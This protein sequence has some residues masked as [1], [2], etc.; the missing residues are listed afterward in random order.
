MIR[1]YSKIAKLA[2][3][4][5]F[6]AIV[7]STWVLAG[8]VNKLIATDSSGV[9]IKGYDTVAYF[10]EGRAVKGKEELEFV[11]QDA[12]WRFS[13]A[14]HRDMFAASPERYAPKFGGHCAMGMSMNKK[15][16]ADPEAWTI[17]DGKLYMK[18]NKAARDR[19]RQDP[20]TR[21]KM[22]EDVWTELSKQN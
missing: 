8:G 6:L 14:A 10:T 20:A 13:K 9:A 21:I 11:W 2:L 16:A 17:V 18:R 1:T 15:V 19:W 5:I 4:V 22:A 12:T 7:P 3:L